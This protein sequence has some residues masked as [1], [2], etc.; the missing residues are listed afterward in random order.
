MYKSLT[1]NQVFIHPGS[2]YFKTLPQFIIAGEIVQTSR[3]YARSVSPLEKAWLD[4][5]NPDIYRQ[6]TALTQK[7][8]KKLSKKELRRQEEEEEKIESTAKGKATVQIYKRTYP[9]VMQGK[10]KKR[11]VAIIPLEDLDY[12]YQTN[13]KAPKRPKNFPAALLHQGYYIHYGDKF[14]SILDLYGKIDVQKGILDNP[15]RSIY[16]VDDGQTLVDNLTWIMTLSK[17]KKERKILGFVGFEESGDGNFRFTF[18]NDA[19]DA[20]D[21]SLYTLL[22]LADKFEDAGN[23]KLA[24]QV[25]KL[26][27]KLLKM[28][29]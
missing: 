22:Q 25:G 23:K 4:D 14:F 19:F 13:E 24:D 29:E 28:V 12:L 6:L 2:A 15:P 26:Y 27:G 18:S 9:T 7:G 1:A 21:S 16:T 20:L 17:S 3:M 8:E 10:K 5:I 11:V